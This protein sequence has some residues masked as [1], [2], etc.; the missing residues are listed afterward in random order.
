VATVDRVV[1]FRLPF[2]RGAL[3]YA[4][5]NLRLFWYLIFTK[6]DIIWAND[7]DTLLPAFIVARWR[8]KKLIYDS[9]EYFT[10]AE[11]LTGRSFQKNVWLTIERWIFPKLR[12]VITVNETIASIYSAKYNVPVQVLR[13]MPRLQSAVELAPAA[14]QWPEGK[15][16]LILQGAYIDPDRGGMEAAMAMAL[17]PEA[18]LLIVGSGR[19]LDNIKAKVREKRLEKAVSF[20]PR[21]QPAA[22]RAIT[23]TA[24]LGLSLDKPV[25]LN[26]A[27]SLPNKIFD[28]I[29]AGIPVLVSDLPELSKVLSVFPVG[30]SVDEV[31]PESIASS[32]RTF[33]TKEQLQH[34]YRAACAEAAKHLHWDEEA[35]HVLDA[36]KI[37]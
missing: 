15:W 22:L 27:F 19:D 7:L 6:T 34:D 3:F 35:G 9:H 18:H 28:Y 13:N 24:E 37:K 1:R 16:R 5:F 25:H 36:L 10:E 2:D 33:F 23:A 12:Y 17:I 11:G 30:I 21:Q 26:Y 29:H 4:S 8:K 20:L 31:T 14:F 32:V